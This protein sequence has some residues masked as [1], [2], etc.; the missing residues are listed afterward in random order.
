MLMD[1]IK[2]KLLIQ[3]NKRELPI[4]TMD[5]KPIPIKDLRRYVNKLKCGRSSGVDNSFSLKIAAP[6]IKDVL[7]HLTN[8]NLVSG[9]FAECWK[10]QLVHPYSIKGDGCL[11]E[12]YRQVSN[13]PKISKLVQY[14]VLEQMMKYFQENMLFHQ[15]HHGFLPLQVYDSWLVAA[16]NRDLSAGLFLDLS[17]AF[18]F[19]EY[20]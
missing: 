2:H 8:L 18:E 13:I 6:L 9:S 3:I 4:S 14:A 15:N 7:L 19:I 10:V 20:F 1:N 11:G 5:L 17:S 16:E 12:Y